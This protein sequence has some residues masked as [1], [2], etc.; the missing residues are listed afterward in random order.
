[1][2]QKTGAM[3]FLAGIAIAVILSLMTMDPI[4]K[5]ILVL[6]G[7]AVGYMNVTEKESLLVMVSILVLAAGSTALSVIPGIGT[8]ISAIFGNIAAF[9]WPAG[10]VVALR[11]FYT[12][13]GN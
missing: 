9:A 5:V 8:F 10:I 1:M 4:M 11:T 12:K 6:I 7:L 3:L 13:A 2:K